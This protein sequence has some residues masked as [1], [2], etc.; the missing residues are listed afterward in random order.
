M[1]EIW[2]TPVKT[3][4]KIIHIEPVTRLEGHAK[5][6]IFLDNDGNVEDTYFQVVELRGYIDFYHSHSDLSVV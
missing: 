4:K 1:P 3:D 5:I 6:D 2:D